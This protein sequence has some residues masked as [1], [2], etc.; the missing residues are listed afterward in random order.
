M[1]YD[2]VDLI[3]NEVIDLA[4]EF[5]DKGVNRAESLI[6]ASLII[7]ATNIRELEDFVGSR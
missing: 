1:R 6:I 5:I 7:T 2:D 4:D 3:K